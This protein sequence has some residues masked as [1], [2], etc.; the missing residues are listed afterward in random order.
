MDAEPDAI[1][2][3]VRRLVDEYRHR[4]L[5]FLRCDYYPI[6]RADILRTLDYIERYGDQQGFRR[7]AEIRQWLSRPSSAAPAAS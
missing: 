2:L 1:A 5:W 6:G 7:G 4:C 3:A